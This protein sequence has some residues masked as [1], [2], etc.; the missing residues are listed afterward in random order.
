[1]VIL[2]S[3]LTLLISQT[4]YQQVA[5]TILDKHEKASEVLEAKVVIFVDYS[6]PITEKRL[7]VLN[8]HTKNVLHKFYAGHAHA[9][10]KDYAK[11]FSNTPNSRKS[12]L[13]LYVL[14]KKYKSKYFDHAYRLH[15]L[16]SSNSNALKRGIVIHEQ[17]DYPG[18]VYRSN[19]RKRLYQ[20]LTDG[21]VSLFP[22]DLLLMEKYLKKGTYLLITH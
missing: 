17:G 16:D 12:S 8:N 14:G 18:F 20:L 9:S 1:M 19:S 3:I 22:S 4:E 15:G 13:G 10:G 11:R 5:N 6:K 2:F 7:Y 21:C